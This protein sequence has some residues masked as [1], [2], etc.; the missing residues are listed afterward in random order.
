MV[1]VAEKN[2]TRTSECAA[3]AAAAAVVCAAW[4]C[5]AAVVSAAWVCA[6]AVVSAAVICAAAVCASVTACV[7]VV[8][9]FALL[10]QAA[11]MV[12]ISVARTTERIFFMT[13]VYLYYLTCLKTL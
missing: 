9:A 2:A 11:S 3:D 13:L 1:P 5:A 6:A 4:I 8:S 7:L 10:P 12:N